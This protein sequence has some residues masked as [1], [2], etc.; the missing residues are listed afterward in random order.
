VI[1]FNVRKALTGLAVASG[2]ITGK[3]HADRV[4]VLFGELDD[5]ELGSRVVFDFEGIEMATAS[6]LKASVLWAMTCG[7][8]HAGIID[9]EELRQLDA[10]HFRPLSIFPLVAGANTEVETELQEIFGGRGLAC[11]VANEWTP[12][13]VLSGRVVGKLEPTGAK[14]LKAIKGLPEFTAYDLQDRFPK[15]GVNA[16]AWNNRLVELYRLRLLRRRKQGKFWKYQPVAD[17]LIY[18]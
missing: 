16:T 1:I 5:D 11:V 7:R 4:A 14:T 3:L 15:E 12:K 9:P 17:H 6:Y 8:M 18:G 10:T 13:S 2:A